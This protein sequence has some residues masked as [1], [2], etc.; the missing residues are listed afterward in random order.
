MEEYERATGKDRKKK[1]ILSKDVHTWSDV[2]K[3]VDNAFKQYNEP[4]GV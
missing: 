3:E 1:L 4:D 2:L